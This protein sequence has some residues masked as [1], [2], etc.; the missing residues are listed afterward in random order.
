MFEYVSECSQGSAVERYRR[1]DGRVRL[2]RKRACLQLQSNFDNVERRN[3][4]STN[5]SLAARNG[6]R[7]QGAYRDTRP[8]IAPAATT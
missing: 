2:C 1:V 5:V 7:E 3:D 6:S 4:E 8:A